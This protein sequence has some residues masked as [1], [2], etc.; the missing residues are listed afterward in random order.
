MKIGVFGGTFNPPHLGH[1]RLS[2]LAIEKAGLDKVLIIPTATP[3]HKTAFDLASGKDRIKMC[4]L[5]FDEDDFEVSDI[6]I[7]REGKSYTVDTVSELKSLYPD[8]EL[9]LVIGSDMLL[10]FD[11]W[12]RYRDILA[13]VKL[14]VISRENEVSVFDLKSYAEE[15]LGLFE[16]NGDFIII[17]A[18][19][20][21]CSSTSLREKIKKGES[22]AELCHGGT[23]LYIS[24][25]GLYNEDY[26]DYI[27]L[28]KE[29]LK[30][31]RFIH[32]LNVADCAYALAEKYGA[33]RKKAY[34]AGLLHDVM[35]NAN[36]DEQLQIIEKGGIMLSCAEKHNKK[37]WH[38]VSGEAYLRTQLYITDEEI[39]SAVRYH[40]TGKGGMSLLDKV[41]FVADFISVDRDYDDV[42]VMRNFSWN[43]GLDEACLYGLKYTIKELC[44]GGYVIHKDSID[45]YN[46]LI[47]NEKNEGSV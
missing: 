17:D 4:Q 45:F 44:E 36:D 2:E 21:L 6:E 22:I 29:K 41:I 14:C 25:K 10:S 30:E 33:D 27:G 35:K 24:D 19:P 32:S 13:L 43:V 5:T 12:Y 15:K 23:A 31:K 39:L 1:K 46:E 20:F 38:A 11:R 7:K 34:L 47:I 42:D 16:E 9:Y 3:P 18:E 26:A 37:T 28:L 8:D 40:T